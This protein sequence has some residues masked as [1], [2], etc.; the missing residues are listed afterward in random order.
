MSLIH[1]AFELTSLFAKSFWGGLGVADFI[2]ASCILKFVML[3]LTPPKV[4]VKLNVSKLSSNVLS[5]PRIASASI[6]N[7]C[8]SLKFRLKPNPNL[9]CEAAKLA[10]AFRLNPLSSL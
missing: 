4:C 1:V 6:L 3:E 10:D 9:F 8:P 7:L 5:L 2:S